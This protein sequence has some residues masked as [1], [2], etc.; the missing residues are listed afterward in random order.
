VP[1]LL[2]AVPPHRFLLQ[3]R[4]DV[5]DGSTV[6]DRAKSILEGIA[7][8]VGSQDARGEHTL[9][10]LHDGVTLGRALGALLHAG[11]DVLACREERSEIEEAFMQLIGP[12]P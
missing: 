12:E 10:A 8:V 1:E 3:L 6:S 4:G 5:D 7:L 9:V 2:A 11:I